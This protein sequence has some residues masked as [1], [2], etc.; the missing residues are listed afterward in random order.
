MTTMAGALPAGENPA[1]L[2]VRGPHLSPGYWGNPQQTRA[3][4]SW[5]IPETGERTLLTGDIGTVDAEG[6]LF[7][8]SREHSIIKHRGQRISP[9]EIEE[10]ALGT[11]GITQAAAIHD[12]KTGRLLLYI[13]RRRKLSNRLLS[14]LR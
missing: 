5:R 7:F 9:T 2:A 8:H 10:A 13:R 11:A 1:K 14:C 4:I 12:P 3:E 6:F